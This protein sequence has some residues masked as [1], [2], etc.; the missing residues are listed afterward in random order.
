L[1]RG[2][3]TFGSRIPRRRQNGAAPRRKPLHHLMGSP[4]NHARFSS[5]HA[6]AD[7]FGRLERASSV[8]RDFTQIASKN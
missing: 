4:I 5:R 8:W 7:R 1:N 3:A 2:H 6:Y